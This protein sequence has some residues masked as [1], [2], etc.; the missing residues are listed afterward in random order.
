MSESLKTILSELKS[1][2]Q[3]LYGDRLVQMVL[4]GSQARDDAELGSDIDVLVVLSGEVNPCTEIQ[5]ASDIV[6]DISL[7]NDIV[8]S[9]VFMDEGRFLH[10]NGPFL[11]NVRREGVGI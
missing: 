4:Y 10:R 9:C 7:R 3:E 2:F 1:R 6:G 5:R 11:R 8:V